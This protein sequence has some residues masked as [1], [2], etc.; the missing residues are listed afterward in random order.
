MSLCPARVKSINNTT[1][2][3]NTSGVVNTQDDENERVVGGEEIEEEDN[4]NDKEVGIE[5]RDPEVI[6]VFDV[7][8]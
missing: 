4:D 5:S 1:F 3:L 6:E 7:S 2:F 8:R